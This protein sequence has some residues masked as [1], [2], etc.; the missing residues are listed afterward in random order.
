[1]ILPLIFGYTEIHYHLRYLYPLY[2]R[3]EPEIITDFPK[4]LVFSRSSTLPLLF[5]IKDS[6]LFPVKIL[7]LI[8]EINHN[9]GIKR[10]VITLNQDFNSKYFSEIYP[11]NLD[12]VEKEQTLSINVQIE[13]S[14]NKRKRKCINDN[15][16]SLNTPPYQVYYTETGNTY[17]PDWFAGEAHYHSDF[18]EDQVEFGADIPS[19]ATLAKQMGLDWFFVTDHS[20]DLDDKLDSYLT[21]DP[22]LPKWHSMQKTA[23]AEDSPELRIIPGEEISIGNSQNRNIHLLSIN[24]PEFIEGYGDGAEK[25]FDNK[26]LHN[27]SEINLKH[28]QDNLFIAAHPHE[29]IPWIQKITLNR[30]TW[31][32]QDF[33]KAGITHLQLI[34]SSNFHEMEKNVIYWKSLLLKKYKFL[35]LAGND[36]HGNFNVLRQIKSP[37]LKLYHE[38]KQIFGS[39]MTVFNYPENNPVAGL[40]QGRVFVTNGPFLDFS[41]SQGETTVYVGQSC[42]LRGKITLN[43]QANSFEEYGNI[44]K[45]ILH[46]GFYQNKEI[47]QFLDITSPSL[48]IEVSKPCYLRLSLYTANKG[49]A[50][51]NP[52]WID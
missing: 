37:F 7:K 5:I 49:I 35:L 25:W 22:D 43:I 40:K 9:M 15:Y 4:R 1:M 26:P 31:D 34:N 38:R 19:T 42:S 2:Y 28:S 8:I 18:T 29:Q 36:A 50:L 13:Y 30:G 12:N 17:P 11:L 41:V 46:Q 47:N 27:I 6:H 24:H 14:K 20:Y 39:M 32:L 45:I 44:K 16:S 51:T 33:L 52:V 10:H 21:N 3:R 23:L 48:E